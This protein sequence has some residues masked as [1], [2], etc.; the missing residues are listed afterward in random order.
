M[1]CSLV[2]S[3]RKSGGGVGGGLGTRLDA[4]KLMFSFHFQVSISTILSKLDTV[5]VKD[6]CC[7]CM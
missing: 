7:V 4:L 1:R 6:N 5:K 2:P 3:P